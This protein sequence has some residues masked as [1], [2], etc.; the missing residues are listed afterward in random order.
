MKS[1]FIFL[2]TFLSVSAQYGYESKHS[3]SSLKG[4]DSKKEFNKEDVIPVDYELLAEKY[5][6]KIVTPKYYSREFRDVRY[7]NFYNDP[8]L[9]GKIVDKTYKGFKSHS[10]NGSG[11]TMVLYKP[12]HNYRILFGEKFKVVEIKRNTNK[13][14]V[15]NT[16]D[17]NYIFVLYNEK[18][19]NIFYEFNSKFVDQVELEVL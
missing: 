14:H 12:Q 1:L 6:N 4:W 2:F 17:S 11:G 9:N 5:L 19:G 8:G 16:D 13:R 15:L 3:N 10:S 7:K 18:F